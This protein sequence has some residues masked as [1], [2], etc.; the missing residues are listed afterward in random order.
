VSRRLLAW[1]LIALVLLTAGGV[2]AWRLQQAAS[3]TQDELVRELSAGASELQAARRQLGTA[4]T[5]NP[6][7][8]QVATADFEA[9]GRHF[10][11]AA[12]TA[13]SSRTLAALGLV[14]A[15]G[16]YY[17]QPRL[18]AVLGTAE[19]GRQLALAGE[20]TVAVDAQLLDARE[21]G[22]SAGQ[23]LVDFLQTS[24]PGLAAVQS[25]LAAAQSAARTVDVSVLPSG[26]RALFRQTAAQ[27]DGAVTGLR[28][29][30]QLAGPL[31]ALLGGSG[32][33]TYLFEQVDPAELRG[34]GG[35]IGSYSLLDVNRG[36]VTLGGAH[37]VAL[38]DAPYPLP[39]Q[40]KY[41]PAPA[42]LQLVFSHGWVF[43]DS[44]YAADFAQAAQ[45]GERL[46]KN[47]TGQSVDGVISIDPW[48]VAAL[49]TVTGPL[50]VPGYNTTVRADTFPEDVFQRLETAANNTVN[51]KDFFPA[52]ATLVIQR[53][54]ALSSAQW[55][56]LLGA[57]NTAVSQR[58]L[59]VYFNDQPVEDQMR[60]IGWAGTA[61]GP[62]A[63]AD[64]T[65]LEDESNLAGNKANH[66]LT[67]TFTLELT[68]RGD[69]LDHALTVSWHNATP[70]GYIGA[71][72]QYDAFLR[73]YLPAAAEDER[74]TG[75][76]QRSAV[77]EKPA[78]ASLVAGWASVPTGASGSAQVAWT[79]PAAHLD[80][81]FTLYWRK[82]AGTL[83]DPVQINLHVGGRM[84][85]VN[86]TLGQDLVIE[87]TADG[88]HVRPGA[89]GSATVPFLQP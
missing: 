70:A 34:S 28:T 35:F 23:R 77:D 58:H 76:A 5:A 37:D 83:A 46:L 61:V 27:I 38:V 45:D 12:A 85:S 9:A 11:S 79:V 36:V 10:A 53:I 49:L 73:L 84:F 87:V 55:P 16:S 6:A 2:G 75:L 74:S 60:L 43:G 17:L 48:A 89:T 3:A 8:L 14:P 18:R 64:E 29:F 1:G 30:Q 62:Q 44:N 68:A 82:Q 13:R 25:H 59:Q 26:Q 40:A 4:T 20:Q 63:G 24:G 56:K 7:P 42:A 51:K 54:N 52:V 66:F 19:M 22:L 65:M 86:T 31:A 67:R 81:G 41:I 33:R 72:R 21:A 69:Q 80:S 71:S 50:A 57:L 39:G 32:A 88:V 78:Q 15:L 47:Q